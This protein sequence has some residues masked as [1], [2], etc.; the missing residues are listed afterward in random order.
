MFN[1]LFNAH[2]ALLE[3]GWELWR[4]HRDLNKAMGPQKFSRTSIVALTNIAA[5]TA[6]DVGMDEEQFLRTCKANYAVA[7]KNAPRWG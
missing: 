2:K 6:V 3:E 4:E 5:V 1:D 7:V